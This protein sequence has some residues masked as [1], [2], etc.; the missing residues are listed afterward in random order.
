[1]VRDEDI[2]SLDSPFVR[3]L[4]YQAATVPIALFDKS[5]TDAPAINWSELEAAPAKYRFCVIHV[6]GYVRAAT[7][8]RPDAALR[9]EVPIYYQCIVEDELGKRCSL[10]S[11][12]IPKRWLD[13]DT[14]NEKIQCRAFFV[15]A[16]TKA[17]GTE[18]PECLFITPDLLWR[19]DQ[20]S[21]FEVSPAHRLLAQNG[22]NLSLFDETRRLD[23]KRMS[24][25]DDA[26][27]HALLRTSQSLSDCYTEW[28]NSD[29]DLPVNPV[30]LIDLIRSPTESIGTRV[31]LTGR[32][33]RVTDVFEGDDAETL[34]PSWFQVQLSVPLGKRQISI[35]S[36]ENEELLFKHQ[37]PVTLIVPKSDSVIKQLEKKS[38]D[39]DG[40][41]YRFW[42]YESKFSESGGMTGGQY[43]PLIFVTHFEELKPD[44]A[45]NWFLPAI[46]LGA[47]SILFVAG[48]W[49]ARDSAR[50]RTKRQQAHMPDSIDLDLPFPT[51][52]PEIDHKSIGP[53][54]DS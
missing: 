12:R 32:V 48:I 51:E 43:S 47:V 38:I 15:G 30:G 52:T 23:R 46:L 29:N 34:T 4:I 54:L 53:P 8:I 2:E 20:R 18:T 40:F 45:D 16:L 17:L 5:V 19:P 36:P 33:T 7:P 22:F 21:A 3:R 1:M 28:S 31:R 27:F 44:T 26:A 35:K 25:S 11:T 41:M 50:I 42:N 49:L 39:V 10:I 6:S 13:S 37:F 9:T 14:L 24:K